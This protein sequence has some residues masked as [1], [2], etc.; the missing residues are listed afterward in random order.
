MSP[1]TSRDHGTGALKRVRLILVASGQ[2]GAGPLGHEVC[3]EG[4]AFE[5]A[6]KEAD[7]QIL[8]LGL[9]EGEKWSDEVV[10]DDSGNVE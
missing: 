2:L 3:C 6:E 4:Q 7:I 8:S 5:G 9:K 1:D 10:R